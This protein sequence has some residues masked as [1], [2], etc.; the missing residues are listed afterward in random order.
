MA[1]K[2]PVF[3]P[4]KGRAQTP[5]TMKAFDAIG[6]PY[7]VVVEAP[8]HDAYAASLDASRLLV[9]PFSDRGLVETRNWIWDYAEQCGVSRFWT[10]DD[11]I[12]RF[13]RLYRNRKYAV[14]TPAIFAA[15]EDFADRYRNIAIAGCN[16]RNFAKQKQV[17]P[18]FELNTRVYSNMLI[19]TDLRAPDGHKYRNRGFYNDDTDLCLQVL[20]DGWVTV[21]FN[22]FL[23]EKKTTMT[24]KGGMTPHYQGDGRL[25]MA[26]EL[27]AR[28][29]DVA[30]VSWKWG[31][32]Q[33]HVDY[34]P[35]R[36]N[37]LVLKPGVTVPDEANEFGMTLRAVAPA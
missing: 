30:R 4:S 8:E 24:V 15:I 21:L 10:F 18:P 11:N 12:W 33:H 17:I 37:R 34:R 19:R 26:Q 27:V 3:I 28:H 25:K 6:Q 2:Y 1:L 36:K 29:P 35:F 31:R 20:K 23:V 16:Y 22:A 14:K 5:Y 9:L 32:W 7:R 13:D